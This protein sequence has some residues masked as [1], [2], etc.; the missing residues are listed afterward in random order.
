MVR[1]GDRKNIVAYLGQTFQV[2]IRRACKTINLAKSLYYYDSVRDDS[3]VISKLRELADNKPAEG[4]DKLY[5]RIQ[6]PT[7]VTLQ[8]NK[9]IFVSIIRIQFEVDF[10]GRFLFRSAAI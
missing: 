1:P 10:Y 7:F 8:K 5:A 2:S 4:Q 9:I 6:Y 3:E